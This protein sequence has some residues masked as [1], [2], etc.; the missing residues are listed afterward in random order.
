[1]LLHPSTFRQLF[2]ADD[3]QATQPVTP[4]Q[5]NIS[6]SGSNHIRV[7]GLIP[8][9]ATSLF[10]QSTEPQRSRLVVFLDHCFLCR[11]VGRLVE[12]VAHPG[13]SSRALCEHLG[14]RYM[15][16]GYLGSALKTLPAYQL[17]PA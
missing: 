8:A 9:A 1:M 7:V 13:C 14:V 16:Q 11:A 10:E 5:H 6:S 15:V 17:L 3:V 2:A 12:L 4:G